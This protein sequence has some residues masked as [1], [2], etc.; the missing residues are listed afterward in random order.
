M[1]SSCRA[2]IG[3]FRLAVNTALA[4]IFRSGD[5]LGIFTKWVGGGAQRPNQLIGAVYLLGT[6]SE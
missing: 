1:R 5:I 2:A 4:R 3:P 6:L